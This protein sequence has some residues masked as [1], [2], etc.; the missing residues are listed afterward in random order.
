MIKHFFNLFK[1][2]AIL[3]DYKQ[4]LGNQPAAPTNQAKETSRK[5]IQIQHSN[6]W[7]YIVGFGIIFIVL[8][9]ILFISFYHR[10]RNKNQKFRSF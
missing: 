9:T 6:A 8:G 4:Y 7:K 1:S 2:E 10:K 5:T 3:K